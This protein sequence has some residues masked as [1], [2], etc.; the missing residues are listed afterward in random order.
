MAMSN[1]REV[2]KMKRT[3]TGILAAALLA[4]GVTIAKAAPA[5]NPTPLINKIKSALD[6]LVSNNTI[7]QSQETAILNAITTSV[8]STALAPTR[9]SINGAP[10]KGMPN[11]GGLG[12]SESGPGDDMMEGRGDRMMGN[13]HNLFNP[14]NADRLNVITSTLNITSATL[15]SNLQSGKS[16]A[17]IAGGQTQALITAL[18]N[19]DTAKINASVTAGTLSPTTAQNR[20]NNLTKIE[21]AFVNHKFI[22]NHGFNQNSGLKLPSINGAQ[23]NSSQDQ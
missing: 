10:G 9:P 5:V 16:L 8:P 3:A 17:D 23:P 22:P 20:K 4:G 19:F 15:Q 1:K 13:F 21:T 6:P 7:T 12:D 18:V 2:F 11:I 14:N